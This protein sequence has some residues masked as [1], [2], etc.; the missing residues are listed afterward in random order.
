MRDI[1]L[2]Y[3]WTRVRDDTWLKAAAL[4]WPRL[5]VLTPY[6]YPRGQESVTTRVL[7]DELDFLVEAN[8]AP[9]ANQ[10]ADDF[11]ALISQQG[12]ALVRRYGWLREF[13]GDPG[14]VL[15][16]CF[17]ENP[18]DDDR[19]GWVHLGKLRP[20]LADRLTATGLGVLSDNRFWVGLHPRLA[21]VYLTALADRVARAN[22]L[23]TVTDQPSSYG[24]LNGW[25][26]ETLA[27]VLLTD[28]A[29]ERPATT[30]EDVAAM[31]AAVAIA[32]VVPA[33]LG[34]VPVERIVRARRTLAV[35]F[36]AFRDHVETL[37]DQLGAMTSNEGPEFVRARL[38]LL[39]ERDLRR[40]T[41]DL[42]RGLRQLGLE[43][44]R[45]VLG[46][47]SLELPA[48]AAAVASGA[49]LPLA[50]GQAGLVA[51]Q[52]IASSAHAHQQA[53]DQRRGAAGYLLGLQE[54]L[55]P[56]SVV[57]RVRRMF[58]RVSDPAL[59]ATRSA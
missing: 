24:A 37:T 48:A 43:P 25:T 9:R 4:Y 42:E 30:V 19:V 40:S 7:R 2:Y 1:A 11:L 15:D 53:R 38:K 56:T 6:D 27:R 33:G 8:P 22:D 14:N 57:D 44:A 20:E 47:T 39:V 51:A 17:E 23:A 31:Y 58:R 5:A 32:T 28:D 35:E 29:D 49:G 16:H 34:D 46:M 50:A 10:L 45:A 54:E 59:P 36:D 52:L 55:N 26:L 3:P 13:P 21:Q 12:D 18:L 41:A